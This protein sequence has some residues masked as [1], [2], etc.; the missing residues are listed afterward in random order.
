MATG[1]VDSCRKSSQVKCA[2]NIVQPDDNWATTGSHRLPMSSF[3]P[4]LRSCSLSPCLA[5]QLHH[6]HHVHHLHQNIEIS[7]ISGGGSMAPAFSSHF[8]GPTPTIIHHLPGGPILPVWSFWFRKTLVELCPQE[9]HFA[10]NP[11]TWVCAG[12]MRGLHS[13]H[14]HSN[15][16][17]I[18]QSRFGR[19]DAVVGLWQSVFTTSPHDMQW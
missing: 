15:E 9:P 13:K 10:H 17:E 4:P 7:A 5:F 14:L 11:S 16:A 6:L 1:L 18:M 2:F 3:A 19:S 8:A 12:R